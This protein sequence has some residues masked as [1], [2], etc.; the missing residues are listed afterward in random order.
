MRLRI[1]QRIICPSQQTL[2]RLEFHSL[3]FSAIFA[4]LAI[5]AEVYHEDPVE[6]ED[7]KRH[8]VEICRYVER[9]EQQR[10]LPKEVNRLIF[11]NW[12]SGILF[13]VVT[14]NKVGNS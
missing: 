8:K 11:Q 7:H 12:L 3:Y 10:D 4:Q 2:L 1:S 6:N 5:F 13:N 9:P 14:N